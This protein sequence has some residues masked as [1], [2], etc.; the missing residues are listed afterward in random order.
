VVRDQVEGEAQHQHLP[1]VRQCFSPT[2]SH[3]GITIKIVGILLEVGSRQCTIVTVTWL[4]H[5]AFKQSRESINVNVG[6]GMG[7]HVI[8]Q[9]KHIRHAS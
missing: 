3:V 9:V 6:H 2:K 8:A 5:Y 4:S 7:C 1:L